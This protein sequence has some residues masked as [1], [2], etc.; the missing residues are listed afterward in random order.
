M[1]KGYALHPQRRMWKRFET[2]QDRVEAGQAQ[3]PAIVSPAQAAEAPAP[4]MR[5]IP[6]PPGVKLCYD[7]PER[8]APME[9]FRKQP[10][11]TKVT[12]P[13]DCFGL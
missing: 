2:W 5:F 1:A 9:K 7:A 12:K 4:A 3:S 13:D 10:F 8:V 11:K 6:E